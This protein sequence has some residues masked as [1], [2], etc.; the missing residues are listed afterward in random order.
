MVAA[1][2]QINEKYQHIIPVRCITHHVNLLTTDIMRHEHSK[3]TISICMKIVN[4]F[5][6]S[7][8][9]GAY[10]TQELKENLIIGGELRGYSKTYWTTAFDCLASIKRCENAFYSVCFFILK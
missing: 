7:Y 5:R 1:K 6:K 9:N 3:N 8:Q 2:R 4:Y 10:L